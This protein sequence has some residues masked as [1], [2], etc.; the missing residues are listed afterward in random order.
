M[1]LLV[2][3]LAGIIIWRRRK[4]ARA[5]N[6]QFEY[7]SAPAMSRFTAPAGSLTLNR[8]DADGR[9]SGEHRPQIYILQVYEDCVLSC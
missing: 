1:G 7:K 6:E 9:D 4:A 2:I 3:V 5:E 8:L